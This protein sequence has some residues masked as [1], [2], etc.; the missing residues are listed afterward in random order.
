[1]KP[2]IFRQGDVLIERIENIPSSAKKQRRK[3]RIILAHG[4]ATGHHHSVDFDSADW[5]KTESEQFVD[6]K[7][8][9][10]VVHQ[11]HTAID[12]TPGKY[13]VRRQREY[14]PEVIRNVTD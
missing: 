10:R 3:G 6:V 11:E 9:T 7:K 1:M 4:E 14:S 2:Q 12:L 5:W 8:P 13:R